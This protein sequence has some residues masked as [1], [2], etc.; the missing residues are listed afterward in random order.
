[1][2]IKRREF[3]RELLTPRMRDPSEELI[4]LR[5]DSNMDKYTIFVFG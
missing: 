5:D 2:Y 3:L 4:F 1:M